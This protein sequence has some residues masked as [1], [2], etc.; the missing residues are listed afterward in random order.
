MN[1]QDETP[2]DGT[3][4]SFESGTDSA[5]YPLSA[6]EK[7]VAGTV[8]KLLTE[9]PGDL[10]APALGQLAMELARNI[11]KGNQKGRAV[12]NE[13]AQLASVLETIRGDVPAENDGSSLPQEVQDF[14]NALQQPPAG[15]P[16]LRDPA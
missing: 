1:M 16:A 13:A 14:V 10:L 5:G 8:K 2:D 9:K 3:L 15:H 11:A 7:S 12:A 6:L 4:F